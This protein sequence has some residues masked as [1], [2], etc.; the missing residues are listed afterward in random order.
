MVYFLD[1]P[2]DEI[3]HRICNFQENEEMRFIMA[4]T[5]LSASR[6]GEIVRHRFD[7][8]TT[9]HKE[10]IN[11]PVSCKD[12]W[13]YT[14]SKGKKFIVI[15]IQVEKSKEKKR[16]R[17]VYIHT[18][19][20]QSAPPNPGE[21]QLAQLVMHYRKKKLEEGA[22]YLADISVRTCQMWFKKFFPEVPDDGNI[23]HLRHWR[24]T[25]YL[26]GE[27]TGKPVPLEIVAKFLGHT[28]ILSTHRYD[29]VTIKQWADAL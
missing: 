17:Q 8:P 28:K 25:A 5:F 14:S 15:K 7:K 11:P 24:T 12:I 4:L 1:K 21:V 10:R 29:H 16:F 13:P 20:K 22:D 9:P 3:V 27:I 19:G 6:I 18:G 2:Y 26:S 23:H